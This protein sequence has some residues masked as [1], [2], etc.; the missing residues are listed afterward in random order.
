[1]YRM[2]SEAVTMVFA[3][4]LFMDSLK[5]SGVENDYTKTKMLFMDSLKPLYQ[6]TGLDF[7]DKSQF[8]GTL[9]SPMCITALTGMIKGSESCSV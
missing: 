4:M 8:L 6:A 2:M 9:K 5:Q 7:R 3:D 1:M